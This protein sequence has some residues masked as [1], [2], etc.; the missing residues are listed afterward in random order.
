[1]MTRFKGSMDKDGDG[2]V[3]LQDLKAFFT[4]SGGVVDKVK[5]LFK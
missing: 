1:M 3:D 4:G 2:D 5:G